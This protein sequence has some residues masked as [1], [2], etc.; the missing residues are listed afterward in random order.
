MQHKSWLPLVFCLD[1]IIAFPLLFNQCRKSRMPLHVLFS[2]HH[3]INTAHQLH[4][5]P[6]SERI[7][8]KT[9]CLCY[10]V[11]TGSAP[12]YLSELLQLYRPSRSLRSS[13]DT[14]ILKLQRINRKTHRFRAFSYFGPH[15]WDNLPQDVRHSTSLPSLKNKLKKIP[16]LSIST[17]QNCPSP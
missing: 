9:V 13:S 7:K 1:Y 15:I 6:I 12:S 16:S 2:D 10:N 4:W 17:E 5:L 14:R 3:A 8:Y 11:I